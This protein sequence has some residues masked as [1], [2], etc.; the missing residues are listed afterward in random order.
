M[1]GDKLG[2]YRRDYQEGEVI[3][4]EDDWGK[5]LLVI[6]EGEIKIEKNGKGTP[7]TITTVG[8][9]GI[10][11][12]MVFASGDYRRTATARAVTDVS[13]W[14][15]DENQ[16]KKLMA[17]N[18]TFRQKLFTVLTRRLERT[19]D[20]VTELLQLQDRQ[21]RLSLLLAALLDEE[22]LIAEEYFARDINVPPELLAYQF[23]TSYERMEALFEEQSGESLGAME[24]EER[25]AFRKVAE[26]LIGE[27][28][29]K[30]N[31]RVPDSLTEGR[32]TRRSLIENLRKLDDFLED[33]DDPEEPFSRN[34][35]SE[36]KR[37]R[38][39]AEKD[40]KDYR[41]LEGSKALET[42]V[43]TT[44]GTIDQQL[45]QFD[46]DDFS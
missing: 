3:F 28:M 31:L 15:L 6:D 39:E 5:N 24:D 36:L 18:D 22:D 21:I 43:E 19:T 12:E 25:E 4:Q 2:R 33:L 42:I 23:R 7:Q 13:G 11:G 30:L 1:F 40:L 34:Q 20:R 26:R 44:L 17:K 10:V 45:R 35:F 41:A 38:S 9:G 27:T 14:K 37:V 8:S 16:V 29:E 46:P 32:D